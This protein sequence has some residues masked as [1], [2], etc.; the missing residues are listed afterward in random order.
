M[1]FCVENDLSIFEFH[2]SKFTLRK[3]A[4]CISIPRTIG[5][6]KNGQGSIAVC[7]KII[8]L[9]LTIFTLTTIICVI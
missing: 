3:R 2:D 5:N 6:E 4:I 9:K 7:V 1:K 8:S